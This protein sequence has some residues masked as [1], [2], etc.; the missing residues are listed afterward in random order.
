MVKSSKERN[1]LDEFIQNCLHGSTSVLWSWKRLKHTLWLLRSRP[2]QIQR[3][4][5]LTGQDVSVRNARQKSK[6]IRRENCFG[7]RQDDYGWQ[8]TP[9]APAYPC[10]YLL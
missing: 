2:H 10:R 8:G 3:D 7:P 1:S 6:K 5:D 4:K 9:S